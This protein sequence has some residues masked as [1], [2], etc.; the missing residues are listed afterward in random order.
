MNDA[1]TIFARNFSTLPVFAIFPKLT[2]APALSRGCAVALLFAAQPGRA[3]ELI[4]LEQAYDRCLATDQSIRIAGLEIRRANLQPWSALTR[5]GPQINGNALLNTT[6]QTQFAHDANSGSSFSSVGTTDTRHAGLSLQQPLL[7]FTV[8]PAWRL[9]RLAAEAARLQQRFT[10]RQTLFDVASAYYAVLKQQRVVEVTTQTVALAAQQL[11]LAQKRAAAGEVA[12]SDVLRAQ[13]AL[14]EARRARIEAEGALDL[15][16]D[17][18]SNIL[19][20]G[21]KTDFTL[22]EPPDAR[23]GDEPFDVLLGRAYERREDYKVSSLAIGQEI[24]RRNEVRAGYAPRVVAQANQ[25]WTRLNSSAESNTGSRVWDATVSV[26]VP[27]LNGGQRE[28]DLRAA[29]YQIGEAQLNCEKVGKSI[30]A[31]VK[32]A[33]LQ[34]RTLHE[35]LK[36]LRAQVVASEQTYHDVQTQ[37]QAGAST[38][39]DVLTALRDLNNS[40]TELAGA[41]YD[42]QVALRNL[43]RAEAVFEQERVEKLK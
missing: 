6:H 29:G 4:T 5:L 32:T 25:N 39:V 7:D 14:E 13:A 35:S 24:E 31:E 12:R 3:T 37:Y 41:T 19:N 15:N 20:L 28:I 43:L 40:R 30:E 21:G 22:T 1:C 8:F 27:I 38:S 23:A 16:R 11:D 9:G 33:W 17:T 2:V 36:A 42:Y 10:G 34:I 18:L 26:Q